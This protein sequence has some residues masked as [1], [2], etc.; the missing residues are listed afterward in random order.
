MPALERRP[1]RVIVD[2]RWSG[3]HGIGRYA[4]EV[5]SRLSLAAEPLAVAGKPMS[6]SGV[7]SRK[8]LALSPQDVLYSPGFNLSI[9]RA[10]QVITMHDLIHLHH[11]SRISPLRALYFRFLLPMVVK[12][13]GVVLTVSQASAN[14][15]REWV[16]SANVEIVITGCGRSAAFTR[17][18]A[19]RSFTRPTCVFVSGIRPHKNLATLL[20]ACVLRPEYDL[21]IVTPDT[22]RAASLI[23]ERGLEERV[24]VESGVTDEELAALYRGSV[25][26]VVP[27]LVEGFGL[28]AL[29][30]MSCGTRV[31]HWK[32][33]ESVAEICDST[34]VVV[35]D[36]TRGSSW[37][38]ALDHLVELGPLAPS[39]LSHDWWEK[40][41]WDRVAAIVNETL[42]RVL[43]TNS[44]SV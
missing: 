15:M 10:R 8:R 41:S 11:S 37:A 20:D 43:A 38:N 40:Y 44:V 28:P 14:E 29:E 31:A 3:A 13:S 22:A 42:L 34:S 5:L 21:V 35:A 1:G 17:E 27:S 25:G 16:G 9:T 24:S 32:E 4:T 26:T 30:A 36:A 12:R 2:D 39:E 6:M 19:R 23:R 33:C 7:L 18:G